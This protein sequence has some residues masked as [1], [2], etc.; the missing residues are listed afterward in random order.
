MSSRPQRSRLAVKRRI[1]VIDESYAPSVEPM[2]VSTEHEN[3]SALSC[4]CP[5]E[6]DQSR[7][8]WRITSWNVKFDQNISNSSE[9]IQSDGMSME[10]EYMKSGVRNVVE[11][12]LSPLREQLGK[13]KTQQPHSSAFGVRQTSRLSI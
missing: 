7:V 2:E 8:E 12:N 1:D 10:V 5:M 9:P 13:L 11:S 3:K 4:Q 6:Y